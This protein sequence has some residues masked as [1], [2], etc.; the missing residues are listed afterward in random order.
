MSEEL[1]AL[2]E[3]ESQRTDAEYSWD[4]SWD[5]R[6]ASCST[7]PFGIKTPLWI[8]ILDANDAIDYLM[9]EEDYDE[10]Y[11]GTPA[12]RINRYIDGKYDD[13]LDFLDHECFSEVVAWADENWVGAE[14]SAYIQATKDYTAKL[15]KEAGLEV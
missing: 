13:S 8:T 12:I 5:T 3:T 10:D 9:E 2:L 15:R 4:M 1:N 6:G 11:S 14:W 7:S